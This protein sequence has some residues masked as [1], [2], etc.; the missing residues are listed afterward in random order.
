MR[1]DKLQV[2]TLGSIFFPSQRGYFMNAYKDAT[3]EPYGYLLCDV[4]LI[5]FGVLHILNFIFRRGTTWNLTFVDRQGSLN[6]DI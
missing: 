5:F 1:R 2:E 6:T 4:Q 3:N